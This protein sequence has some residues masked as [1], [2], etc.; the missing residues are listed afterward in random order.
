MAVTLTDHDQTTGDLARNSLGPACIE[1]RRGTRLFSVQ[2]FC[3]VFW[4][5]HD[6]VT[7]RASELTMEDLP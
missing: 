5:A 7:L 1:F 3:A 4:F 6:F 2:I